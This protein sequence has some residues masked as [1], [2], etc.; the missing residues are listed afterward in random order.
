MWTKGKR[1]A[2]LACRKRSVLKCVI[3][4]RRFIKIHADLEEMHGQG[5][6]S[7]IVS[8]DSDKARIQA[9]VDEVNEVVTDVQLHLHIAGQKRLQ[10]MDAGITVSCHVFSAQ[11]QSSQL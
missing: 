2:L 8:S 7:R 4:Y 1:T 11:A 6:F 3:G 10:R 9:W 5:L